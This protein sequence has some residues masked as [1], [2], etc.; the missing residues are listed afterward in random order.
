MNQ[1]QLSFCQGFLR[2]NTEFASTLRTASSINEEKVELILT[3]T[4]KVLH[5]FEE[6]F[7]QEENS[8]AKAK[9]TMKDAQDKHD[10]NKKCVRKFR[11][12]LKELAD[13]HKEGKLQGYTNGCTKGGS[14]SSKAAVAEAIKR[15][16]ALAKTWIEKARISGLKLQEAKG[17]KALIRDVAKGAKKL[18]ESLEKKMAKLEETV[19][20]SEEGADVAR[21]LASQVRSVEK[22]LAAAQSELQGNIM[23]LCKRVDDVELKVDDVEG[24]V[25]VLAGNV[26]TNSAQG[27]ANAVL[28]LMNE[29]NLAGTNED[30]SK[31]K[32]QVSDNA[33]FLS[34]LNLS[35][36]GTDEELEQLNIQVEKLDERL[37]AMEIERQK[38]KAHSEKT[39]ADSEKTIADSE[40]TIE[41]QRK[42]IDVLLAAVE[43]GKQEPVRLVFAA[44][45]EFCISH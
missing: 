12:L 39:I 8:L 29:A 18:A 1:S 11:S 2:N 37:A 25:E 32:V 28:A 21:Q 9:V 23:D 3:E 15:R 44:P 7:L 40:K 45:Y 6:F 35:C 14:F 31:T 36:Q 16:T 24:V 34:D 38:E 27:N 42:R 17:N 22:Q 30:L 13:G 19:K 4:E 10:Y 5:G 20:K 41:E 43:V 33:S 26:K